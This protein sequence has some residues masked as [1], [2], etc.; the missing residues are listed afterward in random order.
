MNVTPVSQI[1]A[2]VRLITELESVLEQLLDQHRKLIAQV[3]AHFEAMKRLDLTVM[4]QTKTMQ[5]G[6]QS[7]IIFLEQQRRSL[8]IQIARVCQIQG[9]AKL[10]T[11]AELFPQRRLNLLRLRGELGKVVGDAA[12]QGFVAGKLASAV[13][14]HLNTAV[15]ILARA[16][17]D[18]GVY[19]GRGMAT[20]SKRLGHMEITG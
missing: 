9:D 12:R 4:D 19:N 8:M 2:N 13:L 7:R 5:Q 16:V 10:S 14:G 20:V 15:R 3:S 6:S 17:G 1:P 18:T 11:L